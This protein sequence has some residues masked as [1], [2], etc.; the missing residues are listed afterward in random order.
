MIKKIDLSRPD[1]LYMIIWLS[2]L[3]V[4]RFFWLDF[5][6]PIHA[7]TYILVI[8]N[9]ISF[10]IVYKIIYL[11]SIINKKVQTRIKSFNLKKAKNFFFFYFL[12]GHSFTF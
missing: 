8:G 2:P 1:Y 10:F 6:L 12:F 4:L 9:I 3:I 11:Y 5:F 7:D